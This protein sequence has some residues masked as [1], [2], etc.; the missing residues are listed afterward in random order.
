MRILPRRISRKLEEIRDEIEYQ[1]QPLLLWIEK[2]IQPFNPPTN[3]SSC[4]CPGTFHSC[5]EKPF[6][7]NGFGFDDAKERER[8]AIK[9]MKKYFRS[10]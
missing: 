3:Y 2:V 1:L 4:G 5:N 6:E 10:L 8:I 7:S 9:S